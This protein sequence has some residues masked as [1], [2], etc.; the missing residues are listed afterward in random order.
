MFYVW[1]IFYV[2]LILIAA[3]IFTNALEHLSSRIGVSEGGDRLRV[4][5]D[6]HGA[7]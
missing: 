2:V 4:R 1:L 6:R 7:A 5:G 3:I